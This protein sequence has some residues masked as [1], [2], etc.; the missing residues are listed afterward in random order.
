MVVADVIAEIEAVAPPDTAMQWDN[1]GL[2]V[3]SPDAPC[4]GVLVCLEVTRE[5]ADEAARV[6][7]DL[8]VSHHPLI[9]S[10]LTALRTDRP[11]GA[12]I[13]RLLQD[14]AVVYAAHT[15]L[16]AAPQI[17]T[18]AALAQALGLE[19]FVPLMVEGE[20]GMG[21]VGKMPEAL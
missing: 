13:R 8:I 6:G 20:V 15:N 19:D 21:A 14:G 9:F 12:L 18:A 5:V 10:P 11:L 16:D 7:A 17:G 3:G 4:H 2:Q 1:V